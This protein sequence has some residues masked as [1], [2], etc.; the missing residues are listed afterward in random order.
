MLRDVPGESLSVVPLGTW[1][2]QIINPTSLGA[3]AV[4]FL[5]RRGRFSE[6]GFAKTDPAAAYGRCVPLQSQSKH[7]P[8]DFPVLASPFFE[9]FGVFL[10]WDAIAQP[11]CR[12][13][14]LSRLVLSSFAFASWLLYP[15]FP[16]VWC[17][18]W[19]LLWP[20]HRFLNQIKGLFEHWGNEHIWH[21]RW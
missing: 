13:F 16:K 2:T 19:T 7:I 15:R 17:E 3:G 20:L 21:E 10:S 6:R 4:G 5:N 9:W 8:S 14:L 11:P 18:L 1:Q 12:A